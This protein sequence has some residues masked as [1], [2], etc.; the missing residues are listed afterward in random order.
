M[1]SAL[2]CSAERGTPFLPLVSRHAIAFPVR[3][4]AVPCILG[5]DRLLARLAC[6]PASL[7]SSARLRPGFLPSR[8]PRL[9]LSLSK[10]RA[11]LVRHREQPSFAGAIVAGPAPSLSARGAPS[12]LDCHSASPPRPT[13]WLCSSSRT[14]WSCGGSDGA[15]YDEQSLRDEQWRPPRSTLVPKSVP[16]SCCALLCCFPLPALASSSLEPNSI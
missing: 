2:R 7:P 8:S 5:A 3:R 10:P 12:L 6:L 11:R 1:F 9:Q 13:S 16:S 15:A 14:R 4:C